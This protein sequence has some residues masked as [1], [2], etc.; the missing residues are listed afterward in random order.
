MPAPLVGAAVAA[1]ARLAAKKLG[2]EAAQKA[3]KKVNLSKL[4]D[5]KKELEKGRTE[6]VARNSVKVRKPDPQVPNDVRIARNNNATKMAARMKSGE[7]AKT[8]GSRVNTNPPLG[9][10]KTTVKINSAPAKSADAAKKSAD[11]KALKAANK[12][13]KK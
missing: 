6:Q 1:A 10:T 8:T 13:K 3:A 2:Q 12:G 5:A 7:L 9:K 4:K 11:A